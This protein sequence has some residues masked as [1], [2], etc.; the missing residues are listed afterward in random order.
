MCFFYLI[1]INES[2]LYL[3]FIF[4]FLTTVSS[5]ILGFFQTDGKKLLACSMLLLITMHGD[6]IAL[7]L[8]N[9]Q[10]NIV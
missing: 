3:L 6:E 10:V 7:D 5:S 1:I 9:R 2:L 4:G 8:V